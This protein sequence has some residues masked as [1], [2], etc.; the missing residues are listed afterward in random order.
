MVRTHLFSETPLGAGM[1]GMSCAF[2]LTENGV[3]D[4]CVVEARGI[5]EGPNLYFSPFPP[6]ISPFSY[7]QTYLY[8]F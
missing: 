2:H 7:Y 5:S 8:C 1:T 4:I 6:L 3:K